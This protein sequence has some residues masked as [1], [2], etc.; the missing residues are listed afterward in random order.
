MDKLREY[1]IAFRNLKEGTYLFEFELDSAFFDCF[2]I[3]EG[4]KGKVDVKVTLKKSSSLMEVKMELFGN[5]KAEC[6]RCL[7]EV[8]LNISGEMQLYIKQSERE[9]SNDDDYIVVSGNDDFIYLDSYLYE[10]YILNY[11]IR[12]LH[13]SDEC[14]KSMQATLAEYIIDEDNKPT[15]SRWDELKKLINN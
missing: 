9:E 2:D 4:T 10:T 11:P 12:V 14:D 15:D 7:G 3:T 13:E 1:R 8:D 5:V 6:D